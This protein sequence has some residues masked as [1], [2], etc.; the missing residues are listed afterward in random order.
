VFGDRPATR[1]AHAHARYSTYMRFEIAT[2][3]TSQRAPPEKPLLYNMLITRAANSDEEAQS[4]DTNKIKEWRSIVTLIVFVLT[5]EFS[6]V[7]IVA[8]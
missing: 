7:S 6:E 2:L 1:A 3:H 5:S 8:D 4:L